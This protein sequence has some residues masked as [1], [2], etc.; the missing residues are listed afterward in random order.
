[1]PAVLERWRKRH[2]HEGGREGTGFFVPVEDL[3]E[4][5]YVLQ[6][7]RYRTFAVPEYEGPSVEELMLDIVRIEMETQNHMRELAAMLGMSYE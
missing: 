6:L 1:M 3:R 7:G 5:D 2:G 4:N